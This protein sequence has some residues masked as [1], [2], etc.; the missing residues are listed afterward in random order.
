MNVKGVVA[1]VVIFLLLGFG[2]LIAFVTVIPSSSNSPS[3][4]AFPGAPS[5][6]MEGTPTFNAEAI[7]CHAEA[8]IRDLASAELT[9]YG[10][11]MDMRS[12]D[13]VREMVQDK[14]AERAAWDVAIQQLGSRCWR[15]ASGTAVFVLEQTGNSGGYAV[16]VHVVMYPSEQPPS[17]AWADVSSFNG[18]QRARMVR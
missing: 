14:S 12:Q 11:Q 15:P 17:E 9:E 6:P 10:R 3:L 16:Y 7:A 4:R 2:L 8:D 18:L 5:E 13:Q 1:T